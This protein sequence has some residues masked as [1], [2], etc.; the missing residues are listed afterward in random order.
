VR[1]PAKVVS[2]THAYARV[3]GELLELELFLPRQGSEGAHHPVIV[4]LHGGGWT[5]GTRHDLAD[6]SHHFAARGF[7]V[8]A[9]DYRLAPRWKFPAPVEDVRAV[10]AWIEREG[11]G[12][13]LDPSRIV[14]MGR[15][16]GGQIALAAAYDRPAPGLR[17]V[18]A[19]YA[20]TDL[21][22]GYGHPSPPRV[23]DSCGVLRDYLGGTPASAPEIYEQASPAHRAELAP[24]PTLLITAGTDEFVS[25]R[26]ADFLRPR[27]EALGVP[28][29]TLR[30]PWA[31]HGFDV[32]HWGPGGQLVAAVLDDV[33]PALTR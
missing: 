33:L 11:P 8:V 18:V 10:M 17:A 22:W 26:H 16:A 7:A 13:G 6:W 14:L 3:D 20:P 1:R 31:H 30:V 5:G 4:T 2:A 27:L 28:H 21:V 12:L 9:P 23:L 15:S 32:A 29:A 19:L 25:P 24:V